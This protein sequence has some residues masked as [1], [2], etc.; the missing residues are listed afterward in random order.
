MTLTSGLLLNVP[1][2]TAGPLSYRRGWSL[3]P[4]EQPLPTEI[5]SSWNSASFGAWQLSFHSATRLTVA[6]GTDVDIVIIGTAVDLDANSATQESIATNLV[7]LASNGITSNQ[8]LEYVAY[9]GGRFVILAREQASDDLVI[10]TDC[11]ATSPVFWSDSGTRLSASSHAS[12]TAAAAHRAADDS[13]QA[14]LRRA[15]E[16]NT[17]GTL[18]YPGVLTGYSDVYQVLPNHLLS[19][20]PEAVSHKRYY[21]FP[22]TSLTESPADAF[23]NFKTAFTDHT[24]LLCQFGR[25]GISL[26]GGLDSRATLAACVDFLDST[27]LSWTYYN[28]QKPHAGL[29]EDLA[30]ARQLAELVN[31]R[32][33]AVD[34]SAPYD[35]EFERAYNKSMGRAAQMRVLAVAYDTQIPHDVYELQSMGAEVGTGF[36]K[37]RGGEPTVQRLAQLYSKGEFGSLPE[38]QE[39]IARYID[40]ADMSAEALG[41]IDYHDIFYWEHR[42]GRWGARRIQEVD[43]THNILLPFNARRILESLMTPA[44]ELRSGKRDISRFVKES[45]TAI[46]NV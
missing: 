45:G 6:T 37:N 40:Y 44:V 26:T 2:P 41:P 16:M 33:V 1:D 25:I 29:D 46:A 10:L 21:P 24:R 39:E 5:A 42:L 43:L 18:F 20:G 12:L 8:F 27:S 28:S 17:R 11:C 34:L 14:L 35:Q 30:K 23:E 32:H 15:R 38:V 7:A 19:I 3:T 4:K 13:A 31:L 22:T 9:L 36:Y